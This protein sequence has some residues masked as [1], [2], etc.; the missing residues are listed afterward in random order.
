MQIPRPYPRLNTSE[1]LGLGSSNLCFNKPTRRFWC[2][3]QL[4][5]HRCR[6]S[7]SNSSVVWAVLAGNAVKAALREK[8]ASGGRHFCTT[9]S[10]YRYHTIS[11]NSSHIGWNV[12]SV[13]AIE[14][15][16]IQWHLPE[17]IFG[18]SRHSAP[19][20]KPASPTPSHQG[21]EQSQGG[22]TKPCV[23]D[24]RQQDYGE[25]QSELIDLWVLPALTF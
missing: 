23:P 2:T 13:L 11:Q 25:E 12:S 5:D 21:G 1:T 4:E 17:D 22:W 6:K 24:P 14:E 18:P 9:L 16:H 20:Y 3:L 8:E 7:P 15:W 19:W 10:H